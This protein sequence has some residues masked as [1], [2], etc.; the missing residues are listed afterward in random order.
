M[1]KLLLIT[2]ACAALEQLAPLHLAASWDNVGLLIGS[3]SWPAT[4]ALLTIDL[5]H[6]VLKEAIA[7]RCDFIIAYHPP[8]FHAL[9]SFT[10]RTDR[11]S[12]ALLSAQHKIAV[13]SPHTALDAAPDGL[14]DFL[15]R[16]LGPGDLR[17]LQ[18]H[19][20]L[21]ESEET[22]IV[23]FAPA[24]AVEK[25]RN[26]LA[27]IGA[28]RIGNYELCSF[29]I[30]GAGTFLGNESASPA[31]GKAGEFKRVNEVRL[32]MVCPRAALGLAVLTL[33]EFHPY[34]EPPIEIY[35][36]LSRPL[37]HTGLGRRLVLDTAVPLTTLTDRIKK[38]LNISSLTVASAND[39]AIAQA[40]T[41]PS[42]EGGGLGVGESTRS[43]QNAES[44]ISHIGLCAGAGADLIEPAIAQGCR[45]FLTGE[46]RHHEVLAAQARGCTVIL[47][48]H[49][50][51]E[52]PYLPAYRDRIKK[53]LPALEFSISSADAETLREM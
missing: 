3:T 17:A 37:R 45:A 36:L 42:L 21:P 9:K 28:G 6:A 8:I 46:M 33:R 48:G 27:A 44:L 35:P 43:S 10:D 24:D 16:G 13:Y 39:S 40:R 2:D 23:T 31:L 38:H 53:L 50:N 51:T 5:T 19:Q 26:A 29:E 22:K 41:T 52:R 49:T 34:E 14:N 1:P 18:S 15:A 11:E 7:N 47:A 25:I 12:I 30:T 4:R 20:H 32:E